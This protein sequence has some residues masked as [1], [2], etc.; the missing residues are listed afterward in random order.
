MVVPVYYINLDRVPARAAFMEGQLSPHSSCLRVERFAAV[1]AAIPGAIDGSGYSPGIF[2]PRY[3]MSDSEIAC[4]LSHRALWERVAEGTEECA[5]LM[6]DDILVGSQFGQIVQALAE[7]HAA[8][9]VV[10]L[11]GVGNAGL[12]GP[13]VSFG[14]IA[15]RPILREEPSAAAYLITRKA[16]RRLLDMSR[17]FS[18]HLD[19]FIF[20]PRRNWAC[21]QIFP[22]Q[23]IQGM[24]SASGYLPEFAEGVSISERTQ[25][26]RINKIVSRGPIIY[27]TAKEM[28]R[29]WRRLRRVTYADA[30]LLKAGGHIGEVPLAENLGPYST[31]NFSKT[32]DQ[33]GCGLCAPDIDARDRRHRLL[34]IRATPAGTQN[35]GVQATPFEDERF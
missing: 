21:F 31:G 5:L 1:D 23:A 8:F 7:Y 24:F 28:R 27:R 19:D 29:A 14:E 15:T 20:R 33:Q 10:K 9:D 11:D 16:A 18:D 26:A 22:A 25:N 12:F 3:E 4:F 30:Q 35:T 32:K 2:R 6:E 17:S 13:L 34:V